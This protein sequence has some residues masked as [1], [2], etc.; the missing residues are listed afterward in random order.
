[1]KCEPN[2]DYLKNEQFVYKFLKFKENNCSKFN[3]NLRESNDDCI[4]A[5][6]KKIEE[7]LKLC[8]DESSLIDEK[9]VKDR[10]KEQVKKAV[11]WCKKNKI[12]TLKEI[13]LT[14]F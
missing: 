5:Q 9:F 11:A 14:N 1:M 2:F 7:G 6:L 10:K 4:I 8:E 12:P 13:E 3:V